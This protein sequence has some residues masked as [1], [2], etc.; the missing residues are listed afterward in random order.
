LL[1][2]SRSQSSTLFTEQSINKHSFDQYLL[3]RHYWEQRNALALEKAK[4]I[5]ENLEKQG[6]LFPLAAVGLCN[7]YHFLYTYSDWTMAR[8]L[9]KCKPLLDAALLKQPNLGQALAAQA[10]LLS[11]SSQHE[12]AEVLFKKAIQLAP[13]YAFTY[14]WYGNYISD[15]GRVD[16]A[17]K[18]TTM[19][20]K[21]APMSSITNR[22][23]ANSYLNLHDMAEA[24]YYYQRSLILE[25]NYTNRP[26]EELE[27]LPI[28]VTRAV[29]FNSWLNTHHGVLTKQPSFKIKQ[30]QVALALGD[31]VKANN[32]LQAIN[33]QEVNTAFLWYV[34][35]SYYISIGDLRAASQ[36]FQKR[37]QI[38]PNNLKLALPYI[39]S[40]Y[41]LKDYQ[42]AFDLLL[43]VV[44][45]L[46]NTN[47]V[48]TKQN[49]YLLSFY[50]QLLSLKSESSPELS[51]RLEQWFLNDGQKNQNNE[52]VAQIEWLLFLNKNEQAQEG[53]KKIMKNGW[54]P[55]TNVEPFIERKVKR[56][57]IK[58]GLG[59]QQFSKILEKNRQQVLK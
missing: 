57:F 31:T 11:R 30:A 9:E 14:M 48:I 56:L 20:Y 50:L 49:Q 46:K 23:L 17:L 12:Q 2:F 22:S 21:L 16:E 41:E 37:L 24:T 42:Q 7:T 40:L 55:D 58:S 38:N 25:P 10:F 32:I 15:R 52:S 5:Y 36:L 44:P 51:Q 28:T 39:Y 19:A 29:A 53:L 45:A 27:F 47:I 54:L 1:L 33:P 8:V 59:E 26:V 34:Q 35:A 13:N 3:A 4:T 6:E 18:L 43:K